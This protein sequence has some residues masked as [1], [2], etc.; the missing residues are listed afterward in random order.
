MKTNSA[1]LKEEGNR[2]SGTCRSHADTSRDLSRSTVAHRERDTV[3][4]LRIM[5]NHLTCFFF[6]PFAIRMCISRSAFDGHSEIGDRRLDAVRSIFKNT[7]HQSEERTCNL[8]T[9]N[10]R[11]FASMRIFLIPGC[12]PLLNDAT[13][14]LQSKS[15]AHVGSQSSLPHEY[16]SLRAI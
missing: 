8:A 13:C 6:F 1:C 11:T 2:S 12:G 4:V 5:E 14:I 7:K 3:N 9:P 16:P 10:R 15:I